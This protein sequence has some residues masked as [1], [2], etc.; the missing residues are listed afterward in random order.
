VFLTTVEPG[1]ELALPGYSY[2]I[3]L[4]GQKLVQH[5]GQ[6]AVPL[7]GLPGT[8][9]FDVAVG[10][11]DMRFEADGGTALAELDGVALVGGSYNEIL[12][13]GG[14]GDARALAFTDQLAVPDG[15]VR[16]RVV[17]TR[18]SRDT[19]DVVRQD[20][21]DGVTTLRSALA[22]GEGFE[23][24]VPSGTGTIGAVGAQGDVAC[25]PFGR[26]DL[27]YPGTF[28][29]SYPSWCKLS[30]RAS[31][32]G[33]VAPELVDYYRGVPVPPVR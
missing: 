28:G 29:S 25:Q 2:G 15:S 31:G 8:V 11:Y 26:I 6:G 32:S 4:N 1:V 33:G 30:G 22:Y 19:I 24:V 14:S 18:D 3:T 12:V 10:F 27:S 16:V 13:F 17:N 5:I 7:S 20:G 9:V 21:A 23:D